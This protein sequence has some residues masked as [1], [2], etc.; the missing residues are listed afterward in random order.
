MDLSAGVSRLH[1]PSMLC[2]MSDEETESQ[3]GL[4]FETAMI[5]SPV[6]ARAVP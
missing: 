5:K 4:Y 1:V 6:R 2:Q 3:A